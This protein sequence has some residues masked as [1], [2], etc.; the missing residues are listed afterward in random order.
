MHD[1]PH[2][3]SVLASFNTFSGFK[4][5]LK[6]GHFY[7]YVIYQTTQWPHLNISEGFASLYEQ[8]TSGKL[9]FRQWNVTAVWKVD[10]KKWEEPIRWKRIWKNVPLSSRGYS[11]QM[12]RSCWTPRRRF[13]LQ[14]CSTPVCTLCKEHVHKKCGKVQMSRCLVTSHTF[15]EVL[16]VSIPCVPN[17]WLLNDDSAT[18]AT[19]SQ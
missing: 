6:K 15:T 5:N 13:H 4:K 3:L 19:F 14:L 10:L 18:K 8:Q 1:L 16:G 17:L 2:I 7:H 9:H 12:M 11:Y